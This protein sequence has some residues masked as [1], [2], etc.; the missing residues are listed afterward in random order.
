MGCSDLDDFEQQQDKDDGEDE[1]KTTTAVVAQA[2][3]HAV[4]TET[5][6]ENQN[7]QK[8]E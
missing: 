4:S 7:N 2:W 6:H 1:R 3:P 8:N 5:K